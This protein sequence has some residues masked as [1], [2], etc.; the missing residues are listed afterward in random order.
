MKKIQVG[1]AQITP[2]IQ[3]KL[4]ADIVSPQGRQELSQKL[5]KATAEKG[6]LDHLFRSIA[7]RSGATHSSRIKNAE[8]VVQKVAQKRLEGRNYNLSHINDA[9]GSRIIVS[10]EKDIPKVLSLVEKAADKG[11]MKITKSE[12]IKLDYHKAHHVDFVT[13]SGV[14]GELQILT[15]QEEANSVINH[16]LRAVHGERLPETAK[17]LADLQTKKVKQ[18]PNSTAHQLAER[19]SALHSQVQ[20][21]PLAPQVNAQMLSQVAGK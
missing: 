1:E 6:L 12:L 16:D 11:L 14:K 5:A 2:D 15:P 3:A 18:L 21:K 9:Y 10:D 8:T 7:S 19:V 13:P 4:A 20:G 17:K